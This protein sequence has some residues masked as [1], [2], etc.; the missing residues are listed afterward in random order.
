[1]MR[2]PRQIGRFAGRSRQRGEGPAVQR[3]AADWAPSALLDRQPRELVAV[4]RQRPPPAASREARLSSRA[5]RRPRA[6]APRA[7]TAPPR[8]GQWRERLPT[9]RRAAPLSRAIRAITASRTVAGISRSPRPASTSV[10]KNGL[11]ARLPVQVVASTPERGGER[12]DRIQRE[13]RE[14]P[15]ARP[16]RPR[17]QIPQHDPERVRRLELVVSKRR[18]DQ[19]GTASNL[20][21]TIRTTS[22]VASSA[23][24]TSSRTTTPSTSASVTHPCSAADTSRRPRSRRPP[25]FDLT[26]D[27]PGDVNNGP[28]GRGVNSASHAPHSTRARPAHSAQKR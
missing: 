1:M 11:P 3:Q 22:N 8:P 13:R 21:A 5:I 18:D 7:A 28:S 10:T 16:L 17:R 25:A 15:H 6:R 9:P 4:A 19:R 24:C 2:Q 20:R 14:R 12:R 27:A 23:Q 26:A